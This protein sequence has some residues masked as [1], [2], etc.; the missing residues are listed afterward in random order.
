MKNFIL[1]IREDIA[2]INALSGEEMQADI[3]EYTQWVESLAKT[4]NYVEGDPLE[5]GGRY[6]K[7]DRISTYG[8]FIE[9]KEAITGYILLKARDIEHATELAKHCPVFKH[10]GQLELRPTRVS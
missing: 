3:Q 6:V 10:G 9:S 4:D 5:P 7:K 2:H 1:F 8:P